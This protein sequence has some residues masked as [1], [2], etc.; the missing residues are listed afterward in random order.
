MSNRTISGYFAGVASGA[1]VVPIL[2]CLWPIEYWPLGTK[3]AAHTEQSFP[4]SLW[5]ALIVGATILLLL[6][7]ALGLVLAFGP[8]ALVW[9]V[10]ARLQI[11][12]WDYYVVCGG[13]TGAFLCVVFAVM[14]STDRQ[15]LRAVQ[16]AWWQIW[17]T[18]SFAGGFG[19]LVYW[20]VAV[21]RVVEHPIESR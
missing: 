15:Q 19:G 10:A 18:F 1:T 6:W 20:W 14:I 12:S 11:V 5:L 8:S 21:H 16:E 13:L 3:A 9:W 17:L 2:A 4:L 7:I